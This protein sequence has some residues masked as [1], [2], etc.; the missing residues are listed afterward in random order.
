MTTQLDLM[1]EKS[2]REM[3]ELIYNIIDSPGCDSCPVEKEFCRKMPRANC[4]EIIEKFL[5]S[6]VKKNKISKKV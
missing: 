6:K 1:R 4:I 2:S 3:A 5:D